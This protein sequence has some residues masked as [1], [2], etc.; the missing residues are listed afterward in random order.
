MGEGVLAAE[1]G[2]RPTLRGFDAHGIDLD[3]AIAVVND[4]RVGSGRNGT[5][6]TNGDGQH[7]RHDYGHF[8]SRGI[9]IKASV[10]GAGQGNRRSASAAR[11]VHGVGSGS[12]N[13]EGCEHTNCE[14]EGN[15]L[16]GVFHS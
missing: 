10:C 2:Q 8:S 15:N 14:N 5:V 13:G 11:S 16:L 7:S 6:R 12:G 9:T 3:S 1:R 4:L